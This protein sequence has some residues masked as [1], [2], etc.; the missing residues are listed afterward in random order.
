[1]RLGVGQVERP[2]AGGDR[3]DQALAQSQLRQVDGIRVQAFGGVE[4]EHAVGAQHVDRADLGDHVAGDLATIRS[5]RSCGS[6]GSAMS[7]RSRLE[8]NARAAGHG[9]AS[10]LR[11]R[12][13]TAARGSVQHAA[14]ALAALDSLRYCLSR[15]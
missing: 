15:P 11:L 6:S 14:G 10:R 3:A 9:L 13:G 1:M 8:Q 7:S 5:S 2:G 4:L 12:I